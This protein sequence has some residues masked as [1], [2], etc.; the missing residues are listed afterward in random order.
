ML[1]KLPIIQAIANVS[2]LQQIYCAQKSSSI[3]R[4]NISIM[5]QEVT[6][7]LEICIP[8]IRIS[9]I[10]AGYLRYNKRIKRKLT[11]KYLTNFSKILQI[12]YL[13]D[14]PKY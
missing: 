2:K 12:Q 10:S 6:P 14:I 8:D 3:A 13:P 5:K 4:L 1:V 11:I 9:R 7:L